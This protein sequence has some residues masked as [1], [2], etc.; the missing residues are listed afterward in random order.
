VTLDSGGAM[1]STE[2]MVTL[3][4]AGYRIVERGVSH[5]PRTAGKPEGASLNVIARAFQ[6]LFRLHGKLSRMEQTLL[7]PQE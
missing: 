4:R 5:R 1:V 3:S 7:K 2:L 6:E